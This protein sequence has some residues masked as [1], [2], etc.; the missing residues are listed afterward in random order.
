[1]APISR[2]DMLKLSGAAVG[3]V[4]FGSNIIGCSSDSSAEAKSDPS[5]HNTLLAD[6]PPYTPGS[7]SVGPDEMRITFMGTTCIPMISQ[8]AVSVFVELGNKDCFLFDCGTGSIIKYWAMGINMDKM[9]RIFLA[10]LHADHMG[11]VPFVYGFGP[12]YGR[13]WPS[14]S[15]G[16]AI[17]A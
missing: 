10:H 3:A 13:L 11:D 7:E 4:A 14:I 16:L 1:M 17:P 15:G 5:Q 12:S 8:S 2:R 9:S 6:L